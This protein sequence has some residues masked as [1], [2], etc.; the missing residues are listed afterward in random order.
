MKI[1]E[2]L[3]PESYVSE[4]EKQ[5]TSPFFPWFSF[6][7]TF[8]FTEE[9]R[10]LYKNAVFDS[11]TVDSKQFSHAAF[12][13]G[14]IN[15]NYF[16]MVKPV[17]WFLE[18]QE[19][20]VC[21][22][23]IRIKF[24]HLAKDPLYPDDCYHPPHSDVSGEYGDNAKILLYYPVTSDGDTFF[25]KE[26]SEEGTVPENLTLMNRVTPKRGTAVLLDAKQYHASSSPK[27]Y[28]YRIALNMVFYA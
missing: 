7:N 4:I 28:D 5:V 1:I 11:N 12:V 20:V 24:N 23:I 2:N 10:G 18:K 3:L 19:G 26:Y 8:V 13:D 15:S 6:G 14:R 17:F 21:K 25:F 22:E 27:N 16:E 9:E